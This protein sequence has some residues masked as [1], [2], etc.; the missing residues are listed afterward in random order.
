MEIS[1][2]FGKEMNLVL[3]YEIFKKINSSAKRPDG[4]KGGFLPSELRTMYIVAL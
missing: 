3:T 1:K 2:F 4:Q